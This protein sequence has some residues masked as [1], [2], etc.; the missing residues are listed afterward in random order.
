MI[1][2]CLYQVRRSEVL[3]RVCREIDGANDMELEGAPCPPRHETAVRS[4]CDG[5]EWYLK[6]PLGNWL[7][8]PRF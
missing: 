8:L 6:T 3:K 7:L 5:L 1:D 2:A 4:M